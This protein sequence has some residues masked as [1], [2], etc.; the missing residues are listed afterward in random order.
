MLYE[1][2][3][4]GRDR[5]R[6]PRAGG[7]PD[8]HGGRRA[9]SPARASPTSRATSCCSSWRSCAGRSSCSRERGFEP[10]DPARARARGGAVR[11]RLPARHRAADLPARRRR[12]VPDRH[13]RGARS[14][15]CTPA[16]SLDAARCRCATPASRRASG[17]RR[18]PPGATRAA[19]SA[20]TSSTRSR[21]SA[22]STPEDA[23]DEHERLLANEEE[24]LQQLGIPYRVVNIAV[25]ELGTSAAK[26]Y[27]CEAWLPSQQRYREVTSTSNTT[28]FQ[29]RRLD[30]RY[31][32]GTAA[33]PRHVATLNGTAVAVAPPDRAAR[34]RPARRRLGRRPRG[35]ARVGCA[36]RAAGRRAGV[37]R[38]ADHA[39]G[40]RHPGRAA[41]ARRRRARDR[42]PA[43]RRA[44]RARSD[45]A[46]LPGLP[47]PSRR[48]PTRPRSATALASPERGCARVEG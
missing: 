21:C 12:P 8:R 20:S 34:E 42:R 3:E 45:D 19:S 22:S 43:A 37:R 18:A 38:D 15:R 28:D 33:G 44:R 26:K 9:A 36:G 5:P 30:I 29:S 14:P 4:A 31:R 23:V 46:P 10:V 40:P 16:R 32:A 41:A 39:R 2:G 25:A 7:R 27:D 48:R 6:P 47:S 1:R 11:H 24:I 17:A 35:A 13:E